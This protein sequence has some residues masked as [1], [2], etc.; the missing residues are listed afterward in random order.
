MLNNKCIGNVDCDVGA[1]R[2]T[3]CVEM[4]INPP[5]ESNWLKFGHWVAACRVAQGYSQAELARRIGKNEQ[6]V[7][8]IEKGA[9]TKRPTVLKIAEALGQD[10]HDAVA[11]AFGLPEQPP[12]TRAALI[13]RWL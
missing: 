7:Y 13:I 6:T 5:P 3:F 8:R 11:I 12:D 1:R 2:A 10:E 9:P 4:T